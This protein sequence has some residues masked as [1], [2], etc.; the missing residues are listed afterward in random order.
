MQIYLKTD[1]SVVKENSNEETEEIDN[2]ESF[3]GVADN[4]FDT[5]MLK[6]EGLIFLLNQRIIFLERQ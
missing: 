1:C 6:I 4:R 2:T 5:V 3:I